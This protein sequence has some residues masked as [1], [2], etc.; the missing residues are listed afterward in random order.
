MLCYLFSYYWTGFLYTKTSVVF[1]LV[2]ATTCVHESQADSLFIVIISWRWWWKSWYLY[3]SVPC[4][5][6]SSID[7]LVFYCK[8]VSSRTADAYLWNCNPFCPN[9]PLIGIW[10][11]LGVDLSLILFWCA[12]LCLC[13]SLTDDI[14]NLAIAVVESTHDPWLFLKI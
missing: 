9:F 5:L 10:M 7:L 2:C 11:Y 1:F 8:T 6:W 14:V 3:L 4:N 13:G 12:F